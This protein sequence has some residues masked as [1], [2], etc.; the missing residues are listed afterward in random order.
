MAVRIVNDKIHTPQR[1]A[2][3]RKSPVGEKG[4][5]GCC[6]KVEHP[7]NES[8]DYGITPEVVS[9]VSKLYSFIKNLIYL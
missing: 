6:S 8:D 2:T 5:P 9:Y 3:R 4:S 7:D 1:I